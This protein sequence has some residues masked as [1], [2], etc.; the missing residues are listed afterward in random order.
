MPGELS[1]MALLPLETGGELLLQ[2]CCHDRGLSLERGQYL[3][4]G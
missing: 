4:S 3:K 2:V 1:V